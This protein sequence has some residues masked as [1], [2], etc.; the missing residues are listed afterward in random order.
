MFS[1]KKNLN[2][3]YTVPLWLFSDLKKKKKECF[4]GMFV[5]EGFLAI[6]FACVSTFG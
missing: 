6:D 3:T 1:Y 4:G 5:S 2:S